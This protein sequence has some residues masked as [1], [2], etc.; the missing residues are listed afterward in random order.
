MLIIIK[1]NQVAVRSS[2][3]LEVS[4]PQFITKTVN[5]RAGDSRNKLSA[6]HHGESLG[7]RGD[8]GWIPGDTVLGLLQYQ[9]L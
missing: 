3:S 4:V 6:G 1:K 8:R 5:S 7:L 2:G 9:M